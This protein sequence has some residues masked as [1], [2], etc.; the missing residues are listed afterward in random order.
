MCLHNNSYMAIDNN[1][2]YPFIFVFADFNKSQ[3]V[4]NSINSFLENVLN[5][6]L[7]DSITESMSAALV[8]IMASIFSSSVPLVISLKTCTSRVC[9]MCGGRD[10]LPGLPGHR[11]F[12]TVLTLLNKSVLLYAAIYD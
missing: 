8:V 10:Q 2:G 1:F 11:Y 4:N 3:N 9:P 7:S 12:T 5:T 6:A